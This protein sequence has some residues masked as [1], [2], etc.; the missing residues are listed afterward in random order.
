MHSQV[1]YYFLAMSIHHMWNKPHYH[2][3]ILTIL[4]I[5]VVCYVMDW[6]LAIITYWTKS[7]DQAHVVSQ[8]IKSIQLT[9]ILEHSLP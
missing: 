4:T 2:L 6:G 1:L 9:P 7:M 5:D 8:L 3:F